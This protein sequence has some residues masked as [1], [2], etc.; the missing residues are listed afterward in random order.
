M[1]ILNNKNR[2]MLRE[3][4]KNI[5]CQVDVVLKCSGFCK[6]PNNLRVNAAQSSLDQSVTVNL[7]SNR[8]AFGKIAENLR[9]TT[10]RDVCGKVMSL[11][12]IA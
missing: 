10:N 3:L 7:D 11:I 6:C 8:Q 12:L 1:D 4:Y 2:N 5:E 9:K